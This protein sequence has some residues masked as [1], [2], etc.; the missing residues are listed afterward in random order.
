MTSAC[1]A[2]PSNKR[3]YRALI[4]AAFALIA[5]VAFSGKA[6]LVKLAYAY[7]VDAVTLLTLRMVFSVPFFLAVSVWKVN[8]SQTNLSARDWLT[9][10]TL[11]LIGYY[12][13]SLLDFWGLYYIPASLE[14]L[15]LFL[16]PTLVLLLSAWLL[17]RPIRRYEVTA[18]IV[19]Y[20][21]I[22]TVLLKGIS[23]N[24]VHL[25]LG[26]TLVFGSALTYAVYLIGSASIIARIGSIRFTA[27]SMTVTSIA[28]V[29]H[30]LLTH[31]PASL[32]QPSAVY[33]LAIGMALLSTVL[34]AF[35]ISEALNRIGAKKTS[36]IGSVGPVSTLILGAVFLNETITAL[37]LLGTGLVIAGVLWI[38]L[39]KP[40]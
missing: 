2:S 40:V 11:G 38:S 12:V 15:I 24:A 18:L 37:Q 13:G 31:D 7:P 28:I 9:V 32:K 29:L 23:L 10:I 3:H 4:G 30:F 27:Y 17:R 21:G 36:I 14:R 33:G 20:A 16:Y 34:P 8:G 39:H 19:C 22:A 26:A 6:I 25:S 1:R 5:A 35:L